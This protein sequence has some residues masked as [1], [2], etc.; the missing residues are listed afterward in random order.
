M[1]PHKILLYPLMGEKA[2]MLREKENKLSFIVAKDAGKTEIKEAIESLYN[3]KIVK[4][5]SMIT[6]AGNKKVHVRLDA[7]YSAEE[8][9]SHFGVL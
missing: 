7:K 2:T 5:D 8:V 3:V 4:L 9:A 1:D 6:S